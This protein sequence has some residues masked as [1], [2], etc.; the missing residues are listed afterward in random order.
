MSYEIQQYASFT[1]SSIDGKTA[2]TTNIFTN[3]SGKT[4]YPTSIDIILTTVSGFV[5]VASFSIGRN[6]G[7]ND[8]LAISVLT[9]LSTSGQVFPFMV[10]AIYTPVANGDIVSIKITTGAV[11]TTYTIQATVNGHY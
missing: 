7:V 6:A 10:N 3:N 8:I 5:S 4:F 2:A 11:G 1:K 9:A